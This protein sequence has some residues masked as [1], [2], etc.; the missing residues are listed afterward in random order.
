MIDA[1]VIS[2]DEEKQLLEEWFDTVHFDHPSEGIPELKPERDDEESRSIED[3]YAISQWLEHGGRPPIVEQSTLDTLDVAIRTF[4]NGE[5]KF[6]AEQIKPVQFSNRKVTDLAS[7]LHKPDSGFTVNPHN[8]KDVKEGYSLAIHSDRSS[9]VDARSISIE[10]LKDYVND[11]QDLFMLSDSVLNAWH[12]P[13]TETVWLDVSTVVSDKR[14]AIEIAKENNLDLILDLGSGNPINTSGTGRSSYPFVF[15][16]ANPH[17][18]K[19][20]KFASASGHGKPLVVSREDFDTRFPDSEQHLYRGVKSKAG[21]E[22]TRDGQLGSG[23]YGKGVYMGSL[24]TAQGYMQKFQGDESGVM[25]RG[26]IDKSKKPKV[27]VIPRNLRNKGSAEIDKWAEENNVDVIDLDPVKLVKNPGVMVFDSHDYTL[28]Q[29]VVI[30]YKSH[31]YTLPD[32]PK[33]QEAAGELGIRANPH[34]D[35]A[36]KFAK[37]SSSGATVNGGI[38]YKAITPAK[39]NTPANAISSVSKTTDGKRLITVTKKWQGQSG[40]VTKIQDDFMTRANGKKT[41][42]TQRDAQM[43]A[44]MKG[45][46]N[47]PVNDRTL[48]R[49]AKYTKDSDIP[50]MKGKSFVIPVS[51]FSSNEKISRQFVNRAQEGSTTVLYRLNPGKGRAL[52]VELIGDPKYAYEQEW[53]SAGQFTVK[54]VTKL[55]GNKGYIIDVDHTA[56]F[57]WSG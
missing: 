30:D 33:Y 40:E 56:M 20:G 3:A 38:D 46:K 41:R 21:A 27:R 23:D 37:G 47:S 52:P 31:G 1:V 50:G 36:G 43:D 11:N 25:L 54:E 4:Y 26:A 24:G 32:N 44:L 19:L 42:S 28:S 51:S 5:I 22:A 7:R 14:E 55:P 29:S 57:D 8:G 49:G 48:Y 34:H 16:R 17:H 12:D 10:T 18:D 39:G 13:D 35:K 45:M 9:E 2:R 15:T 6:Y 53:I